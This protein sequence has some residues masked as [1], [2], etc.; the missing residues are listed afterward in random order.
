MAKNNVRKKPTVKEMASAIIEINNKT[1]E[2]YKIVKQI[3]GALGLFVE[4]EGK[5]EEFNAYINKK[6]EEMENTNDTKTDG[7]ADKQNLQAD[8]EDKS[9][10]TKGVRKKKS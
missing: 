10:R 1:N 3:D 6:V 7:K 2:L 5:T 8:T 9:S 4:M